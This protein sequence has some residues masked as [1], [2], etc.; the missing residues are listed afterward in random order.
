MRVLEKCQSLI[1]QVTRQ[2]H[3]KKM[4]VLLGSSL[5]AIDDEETEYENATETLNNEL[6]SCFH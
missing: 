5:H 1:L 2:L 3:F 4:V 6:T